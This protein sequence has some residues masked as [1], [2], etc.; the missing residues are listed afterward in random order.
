SEL[1]FELQSLGKI[2]ANDMKVRIDLKRLPT[3]R[4][5][6]V[7]AMRVQVIESE[8]GVDDEREGVERD[9]AFVAGDRVVESAQSTE[10][11]RFPLMSRR[12]VGIERDGAIK[13][14]DRPREIVIEICVDGPKGCVGR[15][16]RWL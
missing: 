15:A 2:P 4:D 6:F 3:L 5:R 7:E 14:C 12:V 1:A 16:Q 10:R 9:G 11:R 13:L 8:I